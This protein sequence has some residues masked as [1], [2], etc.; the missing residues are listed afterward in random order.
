MINSIACVFLG[1]IGGY[2][3][4]SLSF[5]HIINNILG[6]KDISKIG[7]GNIG[8]TN[9]AR[10]YGK[11]IG[12]AVFLGDFLKGFMGFMF[13]PWIIMWLLGADTDICYASI[14]ISIFMGHLY[15]LYF[16]LKGGKGVATFMGVLCAVDI[17]FIGSLGF[18]YSYSAVFAVIWLSL[19]ILTRTSS[20]ASIG[21]SISVFCLPL[22]MIYSYD[23]S[24]M[25]IAIEDR[26]FHMRLVIIL[27]M[28]IIIFHIDNIKRLI[29][30]T[31]NSFK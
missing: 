2:L 12:I 22:W 1:I 5:G 14:G 18:D 23:I 17:G 24:I 9:L 28:M 20:I 7:S 29:H 19:F 16:R 6:Q 26:L 3:I 27:S 11:W 10:A 4:G 30:G 13:L 8:A 21:A 15:P 25:S 31:E